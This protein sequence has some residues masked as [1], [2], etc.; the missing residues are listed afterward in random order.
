MPPSPETKPDLRMD[1][2]AGLTAAA[3]VIPKAMAYATVAGLPVVVGL[4]TA[5]VPMVVYAL[6]GSSRVLNV[7]TTTT[8]AILTGA[9]MAVVVPDGDP[10]RLLTASATLAALTG[11]LLV[12]AGVLRLGVVANFISDPV[13]TGF[14]AGVGMVIVLDQL[15]KLLGLHLPKAGFFEKIGLLLQ[16]VPQTSMAA[17]AVG[18]ATVAGLVLLERFFPNSPAPLAGMAAAIAASAVLDL[19]ARGVET[20]GTIPQGFPSFVLPDLHLVG[21]LLP[22]AAGIALM[23]FA[24][25]IA[26]GRAFARKEDPP[27]RANRELVATG[28]ANLA[29]SLFG[30]M[31]GGGGTSQTAVVRSVG[32]GSQAASLVTA[33]ATVLVMLFLAPMISLLPQPALAAFV[34]VYSVGLI[35]PAEF[36][37]IRRVRTMEFRWALAA[38]LGVPLFGTLQGIVVSIALSLLALLAR[39]SNPR[40]SILGRK[41]GTDVFRPNTADHPE[42]ESFPG[43]LLLR[44]EDRIFFANVQVLRERVQALREERKPRVIAL[45][46]S[47]VPDIEY[48][49]LKVL[50]EA[51]KKSVE[52]GVKLWLIG[53]NPEVLQVVQR[54]GLADRLGR[55]GMHFNPQAAVARYLQQFPP[56]APAA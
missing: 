2:V 21:T 41:P 48:S 55:E 28:A 35:K 43:L 3:V 44:P 11:L 26:V 20:I 8:I 22:G 51:E 52:A 42:D 53:L 46:L 34:I 13:L 31:P 16:N 7:S 25:T 24:E 39:S 12:L 1:L 27:V 17:L 18:G 29:G 5:F 6:L 19:K 4:Y 49:A 45:D 30:A 47:G 56:P 15:P 36:A 50:I 33:G 38:C 54:C 23:S 9:Q 37:A 10:A 14:K 40:I 32:G